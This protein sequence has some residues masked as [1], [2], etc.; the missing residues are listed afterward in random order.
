VRWADLDRRGS[1]GTIVGTGLFDYGDADGSG[2]AVK[3]QHPLAI[4]WQ[5]GASADAAGML[6]VADSYNNKIKT[7]DPEKRSAASFAGAGEKGA[8]DGDLAQA[9]LGEPAG[10]SLAGE[11]L[12]VADT[13]NHLIRVINIE[14]HRID[15]FVLRGLEITASPPPRARSGH[16]NRGR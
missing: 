6:F 7:V 3:L 10:L 2:E 9:Q 11:L 5:P 1:V 4:A 8:R 16:P 15:T 12:Y 13:D 14:S